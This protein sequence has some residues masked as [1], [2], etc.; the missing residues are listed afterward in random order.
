MVHVR[1]ITRETRTHSYELPK[2]TVNLA[3]R[4]KEEK[5]F[6]VE[7]R[8]MYIAEIKLAISINESSAGKPISGS[9]RRHY[10]RDIQVFRGGASRFGEIERLDKIVSE[11]K[12]V[13]D[14]K[15]SAEGR[16]ASVTVDGGGQNA[17]AGGRRV[18]H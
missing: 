10:W 2:F 15:G 16:S 11:E 1:D 6:L 18:D 9:R 8:Q 4:E 3:C 5:A 14:G 7:K 13:R 17:L 12:R